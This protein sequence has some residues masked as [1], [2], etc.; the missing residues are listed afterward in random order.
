MW[1][2]DAELQSKAEKGTKWCGV[3]GDVWRAKVVVS[4]S[5]DSIVIFRFCI[6]Q[7]NVLRILIFR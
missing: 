2:L 7:K 3:I 1:K 5:V 6:T 4:G